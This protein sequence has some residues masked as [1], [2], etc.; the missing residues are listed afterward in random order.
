MTQGCLSPSVIL[1][2]NRPRSRLPAG[3]VDN[4]KLAEES[5]EGCVNWRRHRQNVGQGDSID[6]SNAARSPG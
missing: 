2:R 3:S 5:H 4:P 6:W 1:A